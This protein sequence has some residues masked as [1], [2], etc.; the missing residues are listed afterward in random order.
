MDPDSGVPKTYGS[1][2]ATLPVTLVC[3]QRRNPWK[4][5]QG[6]EKTKKLW[7]IKIKIIINKNI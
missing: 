1:G 2:S 3:F 6:R 5:Y 7:Y 4:K